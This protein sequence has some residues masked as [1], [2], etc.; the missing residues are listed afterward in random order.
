MD[1]RV[2]AESSG[3][4]SFDG[5]PAC[6]VVQAVGLLCNAVASV[7]FTRRA[8]R[9]GDE[10]LG[11]VGAAAGC[12]CV[13][14]PVC[15]L[16]FPSIYTDWLYAGDL[17][18]LT[19]YVLLLVGAVREIRVYWAA[20]A[21]IA[22]EAERRRLARDLHDGVVQELGYIRSESLRPSDDGAM[23]RISASSMRALDEARRAI[24]AL[25]APPDEGLASALRRAATRS[26]T[27]TTCRWSCPWTS[28]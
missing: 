14:A 9:S 1:V 4:P 7:V 17:L 13:G 16:L 22:I 12:R 2:A 5:H 19:T 10:L 18:R 15:Y 24:T 25:A 11:W 28:P 6:F 27:A 8:A 21:S 23:A 26:A 20:Q 3:R